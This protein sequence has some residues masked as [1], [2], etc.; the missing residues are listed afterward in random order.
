MIDPPPVLVEEPI[1]DPL[2]EV[3]LAWSDVARPA[4]HDEILGAS[5]CINDGLDDVLLTPAYQQ[6]ATKHAVVPVCRKDSSI[7]D[8]AH[9]SDVRRGVGESFDE[10]PVSESSGQP[11]VVIGFVAALRRNLE[12][13]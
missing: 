6:Q 5:D 2:K 12:L 11:I 3:N 1:I 10:R 13:G 9:A 8:D 4:D 7:Q